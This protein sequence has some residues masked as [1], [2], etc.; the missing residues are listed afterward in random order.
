MERYHQIKEIFQAAMEQAPEIRA[1]FLAKACADDLELRNE[2]EQMIAMMDEADSFIEEPAFN[3]GDHYTTQK[4]AVQQPIEGSYIGHYKV[5]REIGQGGMGAV[6]LA[7]RADDQYKKRVA[8]KL[9]RG[10]ANNDYLRRRFLSERQILASLDHPNIAKLLDGGTTEDGSPY[11]VMDYIEGSS[12]DEFCDKNKLSTAERVKLFRAVCSAV[13]YAHQ[14][15]VIHRDIKPGN[16]IVTADG[17]PRLLDFGIAKLLNPELSLQTLDLTLGPMGPMTPEYASPE[18]VRGDALTTASDIYSLGVVLYEL[19]TGHRPYKFSSRVPH[20]IAQVICE[21]EPEKPSTVI[22]R[23]ETN[24]FALSATEI[25]LSPEIV[26]RTREGQPEKLRRRLQGDLDNIILM[27]MRKEPQRRYASVEQFSEDL[28]RHIEGLPVFARKATISYRTT[29]FINRN[30]I[31]VAA[32]VLVALTLIGGIITTLWQAHRA[33][34][35]KAKAEQRFNDVRSL[36]NSFMFEIHDEIQNLP[37]STPARQLLVTKALKYLDS[38]AK[39]SSD[40][41]TLQ[42]ELAT[43]YSKVGDIQG[44][45]TVANLG[46]IYGSLESYRKA[47]KIRQALPAEATNNFDAEIEL[48]NNYDRVGDMVLLDQDLKGA[49]ENYQKALEIRQRLAERE[50]NNSLVRYDLAYSYSNLADVLGV[51]GDLS[52]SLE[53]YRKAVAMRQALLAQEPMNAK[54]RRG[55]AIIY[56]HMASYVFKSGDK[57]GGI[58]TEHKALALFEALAKEDAQN[59]KARRE[60]ALAYNNLGDLLWYS[61]DIK[62]ATES[63]RIGMTLREELL[64]ADPTNM[65]A[66]R[67]LALSYGNYGYTLAQAGDA[68]GLELYRKN[69][70]I[71]EGLL[72][73]NPDNA[74]SLRDVAVTYSYCGDIYGL[75]AAKTDLPKA[76]RIEYYQS[77]ISFNERSIQ[78]WM[79]MRNRGILQS[80]DKD[81]ADKISKSNA[82]YK[83]EIAKLSAARKP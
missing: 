64:K 24:P 82:D 37:G 50:P 49:T 3:I 19:L 27:A 33:S 80:S 40:D 34:L 54:Y 69:I 31:A 41:V 5:V 76:K 25:S 55:L 8:I 6:Y 26:S 78:I 48:A 53:K 28:R 20:A 59:A 2:V 73:A 13:H 58:E 63:Y 38:L 4:V 66:R 15:L 72:A 9:I 43:A 47:L 16:I 83:M 79:D 60:L 11:L 1:D 71:V 77:A 29:K 70:E 75:L 21:Q 30:K 14:K 35:Q 7:I 56:Q 23:I 74:N 36:A 12:I 51:A 42:R 52:G 17:T 62:G 67:D 46:D 44:N 32:G 81:T 57:Q 10:G 39:E 22:N 65:Q 45:P 18:Q 68:Q 61:D